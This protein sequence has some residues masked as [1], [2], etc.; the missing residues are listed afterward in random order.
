M[1]YKKPVSN[2]TTREASRVHAR[3]PT[4]GA[5]H[6]PR[7]YRVGTVTG[8]PQTVMPSGEQH[9]LRHGDQSAVVVE[10]GGGLRTYETADGPLLDG[11]AVDEMCSGGRGQP[12]IPWPNRLRNGAFEFGGSTHQLTLTEAAAHNAIHGLVRWANWTLASRA[13]NRVVVE[14]VLHPQPGWPWPIHLEIEYSL[15]DGGLTV[16]TTATNVG[17]A[18]CPYGA[19]QHPYLTL[20]GECID[21]IVVRAPGRRYLESDE[22]GIP[23]AS[24]DVR[25][26][27]FDYTEPREL[28]AAQ[29]DTGYTELDRD[30]DGLARVVLELPDRAR[31]VTLWVDGAYSYVMLFTGDSL[32]PDAR[33][34][35][36]AVEPMT[37]AP[38]ALQSGDGLVILEPGASHTARWGITRV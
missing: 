20:G 14:H 27:R 29:L 26:T 4:A 9:E 33:R 28:G 6:G 13:E 36:L 15:G 1:V 38:N 16:T 12:L 18:A 7:G 11:Y 5:H 35:G 8:P 31:R 2:L 17:P 24:H 23:I 22:R 30:G 34:R 37:C 32:A 21:P 10:V 19:G 3:L 25:E